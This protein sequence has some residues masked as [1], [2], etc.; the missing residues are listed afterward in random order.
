MTGQPEAAGHLLRRVVL[1]FAA[2]LTLLLTVVALLDPARAAAAETA[3]PAPT[4]AVTVGDDGS[5]SMPATL[6]PGRYR[7]VVSGGPCACVQL[8]RAQPGYAVTQF[9]ADLR[10]Y[11]SSARARIAA[12][13]RLS[14]GTN[15]GPGQAAFTATLY[16]GTY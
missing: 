8:V 12:G 15:A 2:V 5:V 3:P 10:S 6:R 16:A 1:L 13:A 4:V 7:F 9:L 14:G 11:S